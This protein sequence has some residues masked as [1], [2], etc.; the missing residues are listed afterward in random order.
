MSGVRDPELIL[1]AWL[2]EG[3]SELPESNR[4]TIATAA[5]AITQRQPWFGLP[6]RLQTMSLP[7]LV[8]AA[9]AALAVVFGGVLAVGRLLPTNTTV[10][11]SANPSVTPLLPSASP[12]APVASRAAVDLGILVAYESE[13]YHYSIFAPVD[14]AVYPARTDWTLELNAAGD[15]AAA[16]DRFI[17]PDGR[18]SLAIFEVRTTERLTYDELIDAYQAPAVGRSGRVCNPARA[19]WIPIG[20]SNREGGLVRGCNELQAIFPTGIH[21][22]TVFIARDE[23]A[24]DESA[25]RALLGGVTFDGFPAGVPSP[26]TTTGWQPFWSNRHGLS[27]QHPADWTLTPATKPWNLTVEASRGDDTSAFDRAVS[28]GGR[29]KFDAYSTP[30]SGGES[31]NEWV[32]RYRA[33]VVARLGTACFPDPRTWQAIT[34]DDREAR[35][36]LGCNDIEAQLVVPTGS[37]GRARVDIFRLAR[38]TGRTIETERQMFEAFLSTVRLTPETADDSPPA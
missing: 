4:H 33:P 22:F 24:S 37:L 30:L 10:G 19:D 20:I 2:E 5:R 21:A 34:I 31:Y 14:W 26:V 36:Y 32:A 25:F 38:L 16:T 35:Y 3:P 15:T 13:A 8:L 9:I 1:A 6:R 7:R 27:F 12:S 11:P 23:L 28:V 29:L 17:R 18:A